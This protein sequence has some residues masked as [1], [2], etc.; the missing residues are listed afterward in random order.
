MAAGLGAEE[1]EFLRRNTSTLRPDR[2]VPDLIV[3]RHT[4]EHIAEV[5]R[6][7]RIS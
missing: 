6:S 5:R 4:L 3:C 7:C 1:Y 2:E